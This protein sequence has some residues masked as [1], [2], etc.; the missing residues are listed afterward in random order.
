MI[1]GTLCGKQRCNFIDIKKTKIYN[2]QKQENKY[3]FVFC[4]QVLYHAN[5]VEYQN[6]LKRQKAL[7]KIIKLQNKMVEEHYV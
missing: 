4:C 3:I 6:L 2:V 1:W 5:L 7:S